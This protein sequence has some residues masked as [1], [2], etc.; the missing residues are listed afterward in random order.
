MKIQSNAVVGF[1]YTLTGDNGQVIDT[2][3]GRE[4]L[5]YLH[6]HGNIVPGLEKALEGKV[7]GD[8][9]D[10]SV[11]PEEGYGAYREELVQDVPKAAFEGVDEL[12]PGMSFRAESNAG[13][14]TVVVKEVKDDTVTVDG[15]HMLA[16]QTLN[17]AVDVKSVR[18]AT[19]AEIAQG[20]PSTETS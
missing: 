10:A 12:A 11:A 6:G 18:E 20:S 7:V 1:D 8:Q 14:M 13:P 3:T 2:S 19:E 17:F 16:G 15:N 5:E 9:F 4:P